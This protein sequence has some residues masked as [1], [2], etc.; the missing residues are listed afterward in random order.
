MH[1]PERSSPAGCLYGLAGM[2]MF[3]VGLW[4]LYVLLFCERD[5]EAASLPV[6]ILVVVG[7]LLGGVLASYICIRKLGAGI[8]NQTIKKI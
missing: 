5:P 6:A 2:L 8:R 4:G 3:G 1:G 7:F